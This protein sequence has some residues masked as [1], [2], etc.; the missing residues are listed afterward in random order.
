MKKVVAWCAASEEIQAPLV[1][2]YDLNFDPAD[3]FHDYTLNFY[4]QKDESK[5]SE[6]IN[7]RQLVVE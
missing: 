3:D 6:V 7:C 5:P 4:I 1:E 2:E